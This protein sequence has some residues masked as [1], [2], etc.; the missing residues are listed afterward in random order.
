MIIVLKDFIQN[1]NL[2][3]KSPLIRMVALLFLFSLGTIS[4]NKNAD[5]VYPD[6]PQPVEL[7]QTQYMIVEN[8]NKFSLDLF[9]KVLEYDSA[10][11]NIMISPLSVSFALSMTANGA[12]GAT[13]DS[14]M[15]ALAFENMS[16]DDINSSYWDLTSKLTALDRRVLFSIAN[17]VWVEERLDAKEQFINT[18][19]KW[20]RAETM[21][22]N[23]NDPGIVSAINKWIENKTNGTIDNVINELD[24]NVVMLLINAIYFKG[25]WKYSFD[26]ENTAEMPFY[27]TNGGPVSAKMMNMTATLKVG[28]GDGFLIAELPYGQGNFVMDVILPDQGITPRELVATLSSSDLSNALGSMKDTETEIFMPRFNYEYRAE[29]KDILSSMG[30][31][32]AFTPFVAD[33]SNISDDQLFISEVIHQSFIENNEEG[34]EAA[35]VTVVIIELTSVGPGKNVVKL[36]RPFIYIIRETETN[37]IAFMGLTGNPSE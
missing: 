29:M 8:D 35:A 23:I 5:P 19:M 33:F 36:D 16:I 3:E 7:T 37:T 1:H 9:R 4:C 14:M 13:R 30:M 25:K 34:T 20:Y 6:S 11:E 22:F 32:I 15:L 28:S 24:Q 27:P 21:N 2:M 26:K 10:K 18:L 12:N 31:G 17:S